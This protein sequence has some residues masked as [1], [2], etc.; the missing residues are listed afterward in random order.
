MKKFLALMLVLMLTLT[1]SSCKEKTQYEK[2]KDKAVEIAEQYLDYKI[3]ASEAVEKLE[4]IAIPKEDDYCYTIL[5]AD[6]AALSWDIS[7]SDFDGVTRKIEIMNYDSYLKQV[8]KETSSSI[9]SQNVS[10][11]FFQDVMDEFDRLTTAAD[12]NVTHLPTVNL[13]N[14]E[15]SNAIV[16][17][18]KGVSQTYHFHVKY[19]NTSKMVISADLSTEARSY[20]DVTFAILSYYMYR[21]LGFPETNTDEFI[22]KYNLY[23]KE[24]GIVSLNES[25][26]NFTS[27]KTG[28]DGYITFTASM[29]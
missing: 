21:S 1:L 25:D 16:I 27:I 23:F 22:K 11:L 4:S 5:S 6:I 19:N 3:T 8:E 12:F 29:T 15:S 13:E 2:A 24:E 28:D 7:H 14:G 26:W 17:S 20:T 9:S 10:N 18:I